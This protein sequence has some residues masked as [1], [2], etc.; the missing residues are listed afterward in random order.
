[1]TA[2]SEFTSSYFRRSVAH[3]NMLFPI[4]GGMCVCAHCSTTNLSKGTPTDDARI[5]SYM[6]EA[7]KRVIDGIMESIPTRSIPW[8]SRRDAVERET[9]MLISPQQA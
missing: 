3:G 4:L 7:A 6:Q 5:S 8:S 1:M 2:A 9:L